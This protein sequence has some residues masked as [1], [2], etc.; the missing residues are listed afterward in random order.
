MERSLLYNLQE[1][2]FGKSWG[3]WASL[4]CRW[5]LSIPK[6]R[7]PS[8]DITGKYCSINQDNKD[9]WFLTGTFGNINPVKRKCTI[10]T[11]KAILFPVLV[12][13]DSLAEDSDLK[14]DTDLIKRCEQ[15]TNRLINIEASI[16]DQKI[17]HLEKY[18]VRSEVF[19]LVFPKDNV[20]SVRPGLT[21]SV[22]DGYWLFI[23]PLQA[24]THSIL[25]KGETSLEEPYTIN[26]LRGNKVH[27]SI[28]KHMDSESTFKLEVYYDLMIAN[29]PGF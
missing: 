1:R 22:C 2:P 7:N 24:G 14:T 17:E 10:P 19:D 13:E 23:R 3:V 16:D 4:W 29:K 15:A 28:W 25:F 21:R 27:S 9:I 11:G 12:K 8:L 6:K 26:Q 5:M 20:Y 18:R